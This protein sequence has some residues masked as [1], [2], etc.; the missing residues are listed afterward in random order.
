MTDTKDLNAKDKLILQLQNEKDNLDPGFDHAKR[1]VAEEL[2]RVQSGR[3]KIPDMI[4]IHKDK[5]L[6]LVQRVVIPVKE[7]P[8]H[9][10]VGKLLG[11]KG[12]TMKRLQEETGTKMAVLGRGSMRDKKQEEE[13]RQQGGK[14]AHLNDELHV[15]V[16]VFAPPCQGFRQLGMALSELQKYL[17]PMD[18]SEDDIRQQQ[19][20]ELMYLN[21]SEGDQSGQHGGP[22]GGHPG[23][24]RGHPGQMGPPGGHHPRGGRG[25]MAGMSRGVPRGAPRGGPR[26]GLLATPAGRMP[27]PRGSLSQS[28]GRGVP[29]GAL[30]GSAPTSRPAPA[31][32]PAP[33]PTSMDL[34]EEDSYASYANEDFSFRPSRFTSSEALQKTPS[35]TAAY[36]REQQDYSYDQEY[37]SD[38]YEQS[39]S[40]SAGSDSQFFD[41]GHGP[42]SEQSYESYAGDSWPSQSASYG[43]V[44]TSRPST[45]G[46]STRGAVSRG[47]MSRGTLSRGTLSRGMP[48]R[49]AAAMRS[50][51]YASM[52]GAASTA[53]RY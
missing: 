2:E 21:G 32:A 5:P 11:P 8:K 50:H 6:K 28:S 31:R 35:T 36:S 26:G 13:Y 27:P 40:S 52:R 22:L 20:Q 19:L 17:I 4:E 25:G 29:R 47:A 46:V 42:S 16:E 9:N 39:Y 10:F 49:G 12:N 33:A 15:L 7:H 41:Y 38:T 37:A 48:S 24:Q 51:P 18:D 23:Q 43:K 14:Y 30:R 45:R 34:Y 53:A 1:L 3:H 44:P